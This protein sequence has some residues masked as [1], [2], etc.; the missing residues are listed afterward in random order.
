MPDKPTARTYSAASNTTQGLSPLSWGDKCFLCGNTIGETDPVA[1]YRS[2]KGGFY[3]T[4]RGCLNIME[5]QG[6]H[7]KDFHEFMA[8]KKNQPPVH[9]TPARAPQVDPAPAVPADLDADELPPNAEVAQ[10]ATY[11]GPRSI[12]FDDFGHL[13]QFITQRGPLPKSVRVYIGQH[14]LQAGG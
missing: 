2:R 4:H 8:R 6:G 5:A 1:F 9:D 12:R 14:C 13:Q 3:R 10:E 7:P 11:S